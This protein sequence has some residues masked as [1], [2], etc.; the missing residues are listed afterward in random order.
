MLFSTSPF[1][2]PPTFTNNFVNLTLPLKIVEVQ[3][4]DCQRQDTFLLVGK[5]ACKKGRVTQ[6]S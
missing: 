5:K 6:Q 1:F 4:I 2:I 3:F